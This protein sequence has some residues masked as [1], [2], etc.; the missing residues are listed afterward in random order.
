MRVL[1]CVPTYNEAESIGLLL[2][3][4]FGLG[5]DFD[6]LVIDDDSADGTA[7]I[8]RDSQKSNPGLKLMARVGK[9]GL[10]SAYL[11]GFRYGLDHGYDYIGEMDADLSHPPESL[12]DCKNLIQKSRPDFLVGSRYIAGGTTKNWPL[13]RRV[14]SR[15]G[16]WYARTVLK[17][18]IHDLTG[19]FNFWS[20]DCLRKIELDTFIS[21]GY[22]FQI[23]LKYRALL[24]GCTFVE[25]PIVFEE[26]R[27]GQSKMSR[28]IV[29]EAIYKVWSLKLQLRSLK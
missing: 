7:D 2:R 23:E 17:V 12:R 16:S 21:N 4:I 3:A 18:P 5:L 11:D 20:S 15:G 14:I 26:R 28:R 6:V 19:G 29:L 24:K 22:V 8:V 25:F 13:W 1:I 10:A 27:A 9:R